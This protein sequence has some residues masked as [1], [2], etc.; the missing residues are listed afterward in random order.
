MKLIDFIIISEQ[1]EIDKE[2]GKLRDDQHK[3]VKKHKDLEM[4]SMSSGFDLKPMN[5][6]EM[7]VLKSELRLPDTM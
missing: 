5:R 1:R 2:I 6:N 4:S 7:N 3:L